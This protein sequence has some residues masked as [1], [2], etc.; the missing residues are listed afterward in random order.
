M[1]QIQG[2]W[3]A[4]T[5]RLFLEQV[6]G[7]WKCKNQHMAELCKVAKELKDQFLTFEISHIDRVRINHSCRLWELPEMDKEFLL[8]MDKKYLSVRF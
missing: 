8:T 3:K 4:F 2:L 5:N 6:Q 1:E 7:L